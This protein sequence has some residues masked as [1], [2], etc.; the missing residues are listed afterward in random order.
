ME[1]YLILYLVEGI[2]QFRD[3]LSHHIY[4]NDEIIISY[5]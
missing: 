4:V 3:Y 1:N 2:M 5:T